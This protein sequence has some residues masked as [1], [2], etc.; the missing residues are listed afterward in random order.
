V[1]SDNVEKA[2]TALAEIFDE[3]GDELAFT[4]TDVGDI[5][6]AILAKGLR[7]PPAETPDARRH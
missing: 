3:A 7:R 5:L 4:G 2:L 1:T 6:R